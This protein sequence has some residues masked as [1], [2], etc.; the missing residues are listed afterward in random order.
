MA[1]NILLTELGEALT[2]EDGENILLEQSDEGATDM[3]FATNFQTAHVS[4][5]TM[6]IEFGGFN[7]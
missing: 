2:T 6:K 7:K 4:V 1:E 3:T 5:G